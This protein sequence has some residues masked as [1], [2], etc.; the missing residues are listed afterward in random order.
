MTTPARGCEYV[1]VDNNT[2][3]E[4]LITV[5]EAARRLGR[6]IEQVRRYLREGK[7]P[8]RRIGQ[9]WFIDEDAV[10]VRYTP[11]EPRHLYVKE[12]M[13]TMEKTNTLTA[14]LLALIARV[15]ANRNAIRA[16]LGGDVSV[17]AIDML[18]LDR[19]EH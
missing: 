16:R 19:E 7:L 11:P 4:R 2:P 10:P 12:A 14:D 3:S 15:S 8:G 1:V 5:A 18:H 17:D 13:T 9:Q 6:S